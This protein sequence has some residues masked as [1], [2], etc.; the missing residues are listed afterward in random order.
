MFWRISPISPL[1]TSSPRLDPTYRRAGSN[2]ELHD[3]RSR[4]RKPRQRHH[5]RQ[6][7]E[8][9]FDDSLSTTV[10]SNKLGKNPTYRQWYLSD[11]L[12][13]VHTFALPRSNGACERQQYFVSRHRTIYNFSIQA[14]SPSYC[15]CRQSPSSNLSQRTASNN[16]SRPKIQCRF[17]FLTTVA[18]TEPSSMKHYVKV[19]R[20][21]LTRH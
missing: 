18:G 9:R 8:K 2:T 21:T 11:C 10:E 3:S 4:R 15:R 6:A 17:Q 16:H 7:Q 12:L 1:C 20:K 19:P 13:Y 5:R 14:M